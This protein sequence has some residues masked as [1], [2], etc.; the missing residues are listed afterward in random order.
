MR[1]LRRREAT[2]LP[3]VILLSGRVILLTHALNSYSSLPLMCCCG[4]EAI[5]SITCLGT[6]KLAPSAWKEEVNDLSHG[7]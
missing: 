6:T 3:V 1:R 4:A 2:V 7:H 5:F